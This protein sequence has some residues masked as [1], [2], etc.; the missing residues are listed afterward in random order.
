MKVIM[1]A[2]AI[3]VVALKRLL[4]QPGLA[5]ATGIG[6]VAAIAL[7]MSVPLYADAVYYRT[8]RAGLFDKPDEEFATRPRP[9]PA[10]AC[11][12]GGWS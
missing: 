8:L 11:R 9:P 5:L 2:V 6:L 10:T 1:R 3:F 4:S 7:T 12:L